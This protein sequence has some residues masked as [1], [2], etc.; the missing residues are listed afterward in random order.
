M[1]NKVEEKR[2]PALTLVMQVWNHALDAGGHSW[3]KLN[4]AMQDA[5]NLAIKARMEFDEGDFAYI[6]ANCRTGYWFGEDNG[7][8]FYHTAV[9]ADN[10]SACV[11][12]EAW[13]KRPAFII[14]GRRLAVG[15]ELD[16]FF[17]GYRRPETAPE[18]MGFPKMTEV[19]SF[20]K[21]GNSFIAIGAFEE[22]N[23]RRVPTRRWTVT[24]EDI[25]AA[26]KAY[27]DARKKKP[28]K[29]EESDGE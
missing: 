12:F 9:E 24:R 1:K 16:G 8:R 29:D 25:K 27:R 13:K 28:A 2:S 11:S 6:V 26:N 15:S 20:G 7:E 23:H 22:K 10:L 4:W 3:Q 21:D 5:L 18:W 14:G 17:S 19:S